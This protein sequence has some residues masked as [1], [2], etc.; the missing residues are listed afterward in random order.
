MLTTESITRTTRKR[1]KNTILPK[2]KR[3]NGKNI[4]KS[5]ERKIGINGINISWKGIIVRRKKKRR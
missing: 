1:S 2:R 4:A 5:G 3:K